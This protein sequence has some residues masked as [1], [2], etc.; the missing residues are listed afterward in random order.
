ME[1]LLYDLSSFVRA[2]SF[3]NAVRELQLSAVVAFDHARYGQLKVSTAF[4]TTGFRYFT[5][6]NCHIPTSF[7]KLTFLT[8]LPLLKQL[9][10][11]GQSRIDTR[12]RLGRGIDIQ[13]RPRLRVKPFARRFA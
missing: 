13:I 10:Q 6:W 4:V 11:H 7:N 2:A 9:L 3:A 8:F 5:K 1:L 12:F